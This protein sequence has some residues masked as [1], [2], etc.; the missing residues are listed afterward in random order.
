MQKR[1]QKGSLVQSLNL[2]AQ[3]VWLLFHSNIIICISFFLWWE[4]K[5]KSMW[6]WKDHVLMTTCLLLLIQHKA[7]MTK[8]QISDLPENQFLLQENIKFLLRKNSLVKKKTR[9]MLIQWTVLCSTGIWHN[10]SSP[11]FHV[12]SDL[13]FASSRSAKDTIH[14]E[15]TDADSQ[16]K[17]WLSVLCSRAY[18]VVQKYKESVQQKAVIVAYNY[19]W[20]IIN[21]KWMYNMVQLIDHY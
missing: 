15:H 21:S 1:P 19:N 10:P 13:L 8:K 20:S 14:N 17:G 5:R 6:R 2:Q 12:S 16:A 4:T 3:V 11:P 18:N 9:I 7:K